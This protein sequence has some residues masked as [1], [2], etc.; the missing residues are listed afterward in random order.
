MLWLHCLQRADFAGALCLILPA[1]FPCCQNE[2]QRLPLPTLAYDLVLPCRRRV[3]ICPNTHQPISPGGL[4]LPSLRR[5]SS[6]F[7]RASCKIPFVGK[8]KAVLVF[9]E[10][11]S[12]SHRRYGSIQVAQQQQQLQ[13]RP[14]CRVQALAMWSPWCPVCTLSCFMDDMT[15]GR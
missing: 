2:H 6:F 3:P 5:H 4:P 11:F 12:Q 10:S 14:V 7:L 8:S 9:W 13:L 15:V 1:K